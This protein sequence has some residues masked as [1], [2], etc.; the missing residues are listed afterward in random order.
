MKINRVYNSIIRQLKKPVAWIVL[1]L[2]ILAFFLNFTIMKNKTIEGADGPGSNTNSSTPSYKA[3]SSAFIYYSMMLAETKYYFD[4]EIDYAKKYHLLKKTEKN[5]YDKIK[6]KY[7]KNVLTMEE[8]KNI[9]VGNDEKKISLVIKPMRKFL[10]EIISDYKVAYPKKV[11][12]S[13]LNLDL[14]LDDLSSGGEKYNLEWITPLFEEHFDIPPKESENTSCVLNNNCV[15]NKNKKYFLP[16]CD[17][18]FT[19]QYSIDE[20]MLSVESFSTIF[21]SEKVEKIDNKI[22]DYLSKLKYLQYYYIAKIL[23]EFRNIAYGCPLP[24]YIKKN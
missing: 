16:Y 3:Q 10:D 15:K 19:Q 23:A 1:F 4:Y 5:A 7:F 14:F 17:G 22:I 8:T 12:N 24:A 9:F 18:T 2:I 11:L 20:A 13:F 21:N 6:K